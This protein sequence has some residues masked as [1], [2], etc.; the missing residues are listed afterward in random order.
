MIKYAFL[1]PV[2]AAA[3]T[4][5]TGA[6]AAHVPMPASQNAI[7]PTAGAVARETLTTQRLEYVRGGETHL[8]LMQRDE[9]GMVMAYHGSHRSH[10]SHSSHS[11]HRSSAY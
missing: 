5:S 2:A 11:S 7:E 9:A 10:S 6:T 1:V 3:A 4:L 8:M